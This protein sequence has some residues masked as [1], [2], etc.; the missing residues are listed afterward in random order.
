MYVCARVCVFFALFMKTF[1]NMQSFT[2]NLTGYGVE[3]RKT[4]IYNQKWNENNEKKNIECERERERK[5]FW[6]VEFYSSIFHHLRFYFIHLYHIYI[7]SVC[8][9]RCAVCV[10][11]YVFEFLREF[12]WRERRKR[13]YTLAHWAT[14]SRWKRVAMEQHISVVRYDLFSSLI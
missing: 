7:W 6:I 2:F 14:R 12:F 9:V 5:M 10:S 13:K 3:K 4:S 11:A 8:W 1:P